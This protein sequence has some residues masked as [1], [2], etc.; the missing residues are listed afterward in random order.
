MASS[1]EATKAY[2]EAISISQWNF[3]PTDRRLLRLAVDCAVHLNDMDN[4]ELAASVLKT[5]RNGAREYLDENETNDTVMEHEESSIQSL[6]VDLNTHY[7]RYKMAADGK[8]HRSFDL[9]EPDA[10]G[11]DCYR[12]M[13]DM[14]SSA[15]KM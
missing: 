13:M 6:L 11:D 7:E 8:P 15:H 4:P 9:T 5:V 1:K 2:Y 14:S 3:D 10:D 12:T